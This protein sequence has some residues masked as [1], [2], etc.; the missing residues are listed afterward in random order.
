MRLTKTQKMILKS[1]RTGYTI[2]KMKPTNFDIMDNGYALTY[3]SDSLTG[4]T[5]LFNTD[6]TTLQHHGFIDKNFNLTNRGVE[7]ICLANI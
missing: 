7:K 6:I 4:F 2:K 3:E 5:E 1:I